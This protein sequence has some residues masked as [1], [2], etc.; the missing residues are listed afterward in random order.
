M[1]IIETLKVFISI[2]QLKS[3]A[4]AASSLGISRPSVT[5]QINE[6]EHHV[7]YALFH[8]TTRSVSLTSAGER[9]LE[10]AQTIVHDT[11][12]LFD[13]KNQHLTDGHLGGKLRIASSGSTARFFLLEIIENFLKDFPSTSIDLL[14][15]DGPVNLVEHRVDVAFQGVGKLN[16][17]YIARTLTTY[18]N[19]LCASPNYLKVSS[20]PS[21][22]RDLIEHC[23]LQNPYFGNEW[24]FLNG[25]EEIKVPIKGRL[26]CNNAALVL[27]ATLEGL[28]IALL[29]SYAVEK[30]LKNREL[31]ALLPQWRSVDNSIYA[32]TDRRYLPSTVKV[33]ID[34]VAREL[35]HKV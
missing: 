11:E 27:D 19:I 9:F 18:Q 1:N 29:P 31:I 4:R 35:Q 13:L 16:P 23:C 3:F 10:K 8:R 17:S 25:T 22:P 6:L 21:H 26:S 30:H 12:S 7:G 15:V 32:V 20:L 34:Y 33:F 28:G 14:I 2:A 24:Y 5:R